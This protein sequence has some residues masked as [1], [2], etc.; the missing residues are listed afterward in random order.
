[1]TKRSIYES[2]STVLHPAL[3][4]FLLDHPMA[5]AKV[6]GMMKNAATTRDDPKM[7]LW[8]SEVEVQKEPDARERAWHE[9]LDRT[10]K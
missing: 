5:R 7:V 9:L 4:T 8:Y 6:C 10:T 2:S 3:V 1:L